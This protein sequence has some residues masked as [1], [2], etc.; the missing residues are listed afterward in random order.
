MSRGADEQAEGAGQ[1]PLDESEKERVG[2]FTG[3]NNL[4][5]ARS[6]KGVALD[7]GVSDW[8]SYY[9][10]ALT[11]DEHR[12]VMAEAGTEGGGKRLDAVDSAGE[13][14]G[15]AAET[16]AAEECDHA[17]G[18]CEHGDPDACEFLTTSCGYAE[19]QVDHLLAEGDRRDTIEE[20]TEQQDLVTVGGGEF[21]EIDV[22]PQVAGALHRSWQGYRG[23]TGRL[24]REL[25][26]VR[27]AVTDARQA[28]R[29]I[30]AIRERHGQDPLHPDKLHD[31]LDALAEMPQAIPEVRTLEHF[32]GEGDGEQVIEM[33][34]QRSLAGGRANDQARLAGGETG[35]VETETVDVVEEN[36][37]GLMADQRDPPSTESATES[38]EQ[39]IP[40]E[41]QVAEGGQKTL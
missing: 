16:A 32:R 1:V 38:T 25:D 33:D 2:P 14:A 10:P 6:V 24:S 11:V 4:L 20:T 41:F 40:D 8:T 35:D 15:R 34:E 31:L 39:Q 17:R 30:N 12:E 26:D 36:P 22:T 5:K 37:G 29:A 9:D 13:K 21:P 23:A 7:Q 19:E 27:E 18:H 3:E 28:I